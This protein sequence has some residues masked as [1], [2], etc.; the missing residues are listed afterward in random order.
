M[1]H[2]PSTSPPPA[3]SKPGR[4]TYARHTFLVLALL[5]LASSPAFAGPPASVSFPEDTDG[6]VLTALP[7]HS[8]VTIEFQVQVVGPPLNVAASQVCNQAQVNGENPV[9]S[10]PFGVASNDPTTAAALDATCTSLLPLDWGD[11]PD[12]TYPTLAANDGA[13]HE[14]TGPMLG[15]ARDGDADGQPNATATGD[16]TD[17]GGDDE[18]GVTFGPLVAGG[19]PAAVTVVASAPGILDAWLDFDGDGSWDDPGERIFSGTALTAGANNLSISVPAGAS[20]GLVTFA[21]FRLSTAGVAA[22]TGAA[23]DGEV[24][25]YRVTLANP[26][27][28]VTK[29]PAPASLPEP[30][31]PVVYTAQ[32]ANTGDVPVALASLV[33]SPYGDV[34]Q[35]QG[36]ITATDCSLPQNIAVASSYTCT[37]TVATDC[38]GGDTVDDTLSAG[39]TAADVAVAAMGSASVSCTGAAPSLAVS[40]AVTS[41]N[42]AQ[43]PEPGGAATYSVEVTNTSATSDPVT[44][45]SLSDDVFGDLAALGNCGANVVGQN[46]APGASVTCQFTGNV[47]GNA[48]DVVTNTVTASST[49]D[50]GEPATGS[51][52]AAVTLTGVDPS[53]NVVKTA[54]PTS[55]EE[56]GGSV[57]FTVTVTN[58]SVTSDPV[59]LESLSDDQAG[60]LNGQGTCAVPQVIAP[61]GS[62]SCQFTFAVNGNTGD[63]VTNIVTAS[64]LD[65]ER[66]PF[67]G[68]DS[69]TVEITDV[70][71]SITVTKT[72]SVTEV[73]EPG[74]PVDFT[75]RIT[76]TSVSSDPVTLTVLT[77]DGVGLDG[78]GTCTLPQTIA[79]DPPGSFYE[80]VFS[81]PVTGTAGDVVTDTVAASGTDDDGTS[82]AGQGTADVGVVGTDFGDAPDPT[83]PTLLANDGAR[84]R[85]PAPLV[86]H[87]GALIDHETDGQ[88]TA[89]A[90]GD[91]STGAADEDGVV[92]T[93]VPAPDSLA[94]VDVT[95]SSAGILDAW[96]DFT[97]DGDWDDPGERIFES[98]PVT[99]GQNGL[100]YEV[101]DLVLPA[102][103]IS[104]FR[105]SSEGVPSPTGF[106]PDGEVEDHVVS[107]DQV[108]PTVVDLTVNGDTL[109]A[110]D[111]FANAVGE[112]R[113]DAFVVTFDEPM[114]GIADPANYR[115]VTAG[116]DGVLD[117][118]SCADVNDDVLVTPVSLEDANP[119]VTLAFPGAVPDGLYRLVVCDSL[120]DIA[121]NALDGDAD[122]A[123][124]PSLV[125]ERFRIDARNLFMNGH[126]DCDLDPWTAT[127]A[128]TPNVVADAADADGAA[129]SGSIL[130]LDVDT[131]GFGVEQCL[132][133]TPSSPWEADPYRLTA[134]FEI[135]Q[136]PASALLALTCDL[137]A[138]PACA[139]TPVGQITANAG[140]TQDGAGWL[141]TPTQ[142]PTEVTVGADLF[143]TCTVDVTRG[144]SPLDVGLD[145]LILDGQSPI[146]ADGFESG[147]TASWSQEQP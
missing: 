142:P 57:T 12:P 63:M 102:E 44:I 125:I 147:T 111:V 95:A 74:G 82:V 137:F 47:N 65:D 13:R 16:D 56:P 66:E 28:S 115:L 35:V 130:A 48:G 22:P 70:E 105:L 73:T 43:L 93:S 143:A 107:S 87:L 29:T 71:P 84:H 100:T 52:A 17:A 41:P 51:G 58:T 133:I 88:P 110:C 54:D 46:V 146:F 62:Y 14:A 30:G 92:F 114:V 6:N 79:A 33:D 64:G 4:A 136:S 24:E 121:G 127:P 50:E 135:E 139:G 108:P 3:G 53:V 103:M 8:R 10:A 55:V 7:A 124:G 91:D 1:G 120:T 83:F 132:A 77:E 27:I 129:D 49:D 20:P 109:E 123:E 106:A 26:G 19:A 134:R 122:G 2:H 116:A 96:I 138:D 72:P 15:A 76:N 104:R 119:T 94:T 85:I 60:D 31:G 34:T 68:S 97:G 128:G 75:V 112:G 25:D 18:D 117:T 140:L 89:S 118:T 144:G 67:T 5:T 23:P 32:V 98:Q 81:N 86:L 42:P 21:R 113:V 145:Q 141:A 101:P 61:G 69:A 99:A 45:S 59:T 126:F 39:G 38:D 78:V 90:D 9:D 36:S 37:F 131:T 40:T 80:C 11:A